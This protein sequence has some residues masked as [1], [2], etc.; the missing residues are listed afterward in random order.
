[1]QIQ[2]D[3]RHAPPKQSPLWFVL[4]AGLLLIAHVT[5]TQAASVDA[6]VLAKYDVNKN[7]VLDASEAAARDKDLRLAAEGDERNNPVQLSPFEVNTSKDTGYVAG[8]S[9]AGGRADTALKITPASISVMTKEFLDDFNITDMNQ[10]AAWTLSMEPPTGG[11]S[12]AF[13]GNR[14]QSNFRNAGGGGNYPSRNYSLFYFVADSYNTER[15]EFSRG[16]NALL[17][18]DAGVGGTQGSLTKQARFKERR[19]SVNLQGDS[20]HGYRTTLDTSYGFERVAFRLNV[21]KQN[22]KAYQNGTS[23]QQNAFTIAASFKLTQK[24]QLRA[25]YERSTELNVQYRKSY[26]ENASIW[27]RKTFNDNNTTITN[28]NSFGLEQVSATTD[29]YVYNFA[30]PQYGLINYVGNQYRTRGLGYQIPWA[31]RP[32]IPNFK[33]GVSKKFNLGPADSLADRDLNYRAVYLEHQF[34]PDLFV[35]IAWL[36]HDIDPITRYTEQLANDYRI[37]VNRLLPN[38]QPNPGFGR[39]YADVGQSTQ[40]QQNGVDD[41]RF[42]SSYK[43]EVPTWFDLKQR[44]SMIGGYRIDLYEARTR[45]IRWVNNPAQPSPQNAANQFRY[46]IY[47]DQPN[48]SIRN[49]LPPPNNNGMIFREV[50]TGFAAHNDRRLTYGQ[51]VSQTTFWDDRLALIL[52]F[53]RDKNKDDVLGNVTVN[54]TSFIGDNVI[55]GAQNPVTLQNEAGRHGRLT[56]TRDSKNAGV[57]VYPIP[58]L[59]ALGFTANYSENFTIPSTGA[60]LITGER[61]GPPVGKGK[62]FGIRYSLPNNKAYATLTY[63]NTKQL[64]NIIAF[65]SQADIQNIWLNLGYTDPQLTTAF[66]YRDISS[67]ELK[68]LEFEV[69]AN[70]TRNLTLTANYSRPR[71]YVISDS[72][73]RQAYVAAHLAEW[74]AGAAAAPGTTLN[75]H[76]II[77]PGVITTAIQNIQNSLNGLTIGSLANNNLDYSANLAGTYRLREGKLKGLGINAGVNLRGRRKVSSVDAQIKY[78]TTNPTVAQ[79]RQ[80]AFDYLW[81]PSTFAATAGISYIHRY[82][83]MTARYQL[84]VSNL[85]NDDSVIWNGYATI[86]ANQLLNGNPRMQVRTAGNGGGGSTLVQPDPRKFTLST[87]LSF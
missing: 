34:A 51:V 86:A 3:V 57:V 46:R 19:T 56:T 18:G 45:G 20:F 70:P 7:G 44:F 39:A 87:T 74:N 36:S 22:I 82:K 17:F 80:A 43:F 12:G 55:L 48:P 10:A 41:Y 6:A 63:Y 68:G 65:G 72:E 54:G 5:R 1:M 85:L 15:F 8:N 29:Y 25:E 49:L 79:T 69:T 35:Q 32:D 60:P 14:F 40:Y 37:D 9:L 28:P 4:S 42:L 26:A 59:P 75:G 67:N 31:G 24:T 13:G 62:E 50:D 38:G 33:P 11:E 64:G 30:A 73:F 53:R 47:W 61:P 71:R 77:D 81:V 16:P 76:T 52:G 2:N 21:L 58:R 27:D 78:N 84:N 83:K 23:N 66:L